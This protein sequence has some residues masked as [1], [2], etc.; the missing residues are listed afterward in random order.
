MGNLGPRRFALIAETR[1]AN[2]ND[3]VVILDRRIAG[4]RRNLESDWL[5][6]ESLV[7]LLNLLVGERKSDW[8]GGG[9]P[10]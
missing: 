1:S 8:L 2:V 3:V 7:P 5:K 4:D 10:V 6:M 9:N